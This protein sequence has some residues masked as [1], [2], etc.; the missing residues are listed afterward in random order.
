MN[1]LILGPQGSGKGTQARR[2]ASAFEM[3][4]FDMG[5]YLRKLAEEDPEIDKIVNERGA[6]LPENISIPL[7]LN[8]LSQKAKNRDGIFFDGFPRTIGQLNALDVWLAEKNKKLDKVIFLKV[9]ED[10]SIRRLSARRICKSCGR[11]YNLVT[12]P[13]LENNC[14]CGGELDQREDDTPEAIRERLAWSNTL[15]KEILDEFKKRQILSEVDGE[16]PIKQ[17]TIEI[18]DLF[19]E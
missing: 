10:E 19:K 6:F 14:A 12:N 3:F 2:V 8:Y 9:S 13:P 16:R 11:I 17:I 7:A 15:N 1:I 5:K 4:Y 18:M